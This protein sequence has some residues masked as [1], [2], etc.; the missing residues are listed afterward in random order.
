MTLKA[1]R[2]RRG[3]GVRAF[4]IWVAA[5]G[6]DGASAQADPVADII[7]IHIAAMGGA[8]RIEALKA[9]RATGEV[10]SGGKTV[11]FTLIAA[12]P[13]RVRERGP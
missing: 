4:G 1:K 3:F 12:R 13:D 2:Q 9:L 10:T 11:R 5:V 8:S 7:A 6:I